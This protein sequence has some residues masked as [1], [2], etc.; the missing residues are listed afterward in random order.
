MI[1]VLVSSCLLGEPVRYHGGD[2][3]CVSDVLERWGREG[4]LVSACPETAAGLPVPRPPAEIAGGDGH[5]VLEGEAFVGDSTGAD[6]TAAFLQG[7]RATLAS[8]RAH[9]VRL[10]ILKDGS[11]SCATSYIHDGTFRS[12]RAPGQGVTA[13]LLS[14]A[15][16]RVFN[17]RQIG[18]AAAYLQAL[19]AT[20]PARG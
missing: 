1:R 20:P 18:E 10:A 2:A 5:A 3:E 15:G 11:P 4:R 8:A 7:A 17:E 6:V 14:E 13:A 19:E 9:G 16:I 12:Q